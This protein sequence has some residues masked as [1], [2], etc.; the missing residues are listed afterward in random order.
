MLLAPVGEH[1]ADNVDRQG[2][3]NENQTEKL[4]WDGINTVLWSRL[5]PRIL[6]AATTAPISG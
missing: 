2:E 6:A 5:P 4:I 1:G 3:A